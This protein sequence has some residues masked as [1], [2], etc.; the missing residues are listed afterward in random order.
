MK[1]YDQSL[2]YL[3]TALDAAKVGG[4]EKLDAV[5]RLNSFVRAVETELEPDVEFDAV[6]AHEKA[7]STSLDG[8]SVF[9]DRPRQLWLF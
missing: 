8:R 1:T 9:N 3:R 2:D 5:R 6:V 4:R 7:I